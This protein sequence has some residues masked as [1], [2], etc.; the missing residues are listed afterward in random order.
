[1]SFPRLFWLWLNLGYLRLLLP[2]LVLASLILSVSAQSNPSPPSTST[3][4]ANV[5]VIEETSSFTT[6]SAARSGTQTLSLVAVLPTVVNVT[7]TIAPTPTSSINASAS[8]SSTSS[9]TILA[10]KIDPA[11]GVLGSVLILTGL[12]SAFLGHKNR[13]T[14]FFLIGFYTLSL[15]CFALIAN[16][17]ILRSVNPPS[18]T[19]RGMFVLS[20][21][22]AGAAGGGFAIFFW[23][24]TK[25][26][27][28]A[29]GGLAFGLWIQC[30]RDGGLIRP[31]GIRWLM[32]IFCSVIGFVLCTIPK[33]HYQILLIATAFVGASAVVLGAD[34]FSTA[35]LKEF[36]VWNIGFRKLFPK[37]I[38]HNIQFPV[39]QAMQIELGLIGAV[40]L[41]GIA[42]QL[43]ILHVLRRKLKEIAAEQKRRERQDNAE[44]AERFSKLELEKAEW[45]KEHPGLDK[46]DRRYSEFSGTT[47]LRGGDKPDDS[48][49]G[50]RPRRS[51]GLSEF[52]AAGTPE[53]ELKRAAMK[54]PQGAG[55]LPVLDLGSDI[56]DDVPRAFV[57]GDI[58]TSDFSGA[59]VVDLKA[60]ESLL[61]EI[62]T[63]RRSIEVLKAETPQ[64]SSGSSSRQPSVATSGH[65]SSVSRART[66]SYD[67]NGTTLVPSYQRPPR[68]P[69]PRAR[70]QSMD[71][72]TFDAH[73]GHS[74]GRPTSAP[75]RSDDW[76]S[77]LRDRKLLQPPS[78]VSAPIATTPVPAVVSTPR[79][80][81]PAAVQ[82]A[83]LRRQMRENL[84]E[85]DAAEGDKL[86]RPV[87]T[88]NHGSASAPQKVQH[89]RVASSPLSGSY[90]PPTIL[91]PRK[92]TPPPAQQPR[93]VAYEELTERHREKL[94]E[95]QAPL[96]NAEKEQAELDVAKARWERSKAAERQA[97]TKRQAERAAAQA[98]E[99]R[100]RHSE[101]TTQEK[102][103]PNRQPSTPRGPP[104]T[105]HS[106]SKS[107]D[108]L[109]VIS[110]STGRPSPARL[111]MLKVEDWQQYQAEQGHLSVTPI[112]RDSGVP[113]PDSKGQE[114]RSNRR[115]AGHPREPPN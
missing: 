85:A 14:S 41:M 33:I 39:S 65:P 101:D 109:G 115:T 37:Y 25:Y 8:A 73:I 19:L 45:E 6:T 74:I 55:V 69:D 20:S 53:E 108:K 26:F 100:R 87:S 5:T 30:F 103:K 72:P 61:Q 44:A 50:T 36:Y 11:F 59:K 92:V 66:L 49:L 94:R 113:F 77:Y 28:G 63:I 82:D 114:H 40:A 52:L 76:D 43:R 79:P 17:G 3:I 84:L 13:W 32:F 78:G 95:L 97:V 96:T 90:M 46:Y 68:Q 110:N 88:T 47:L 81:V 106:R 21:F 18:T 23:K 31:I 48:N 64:P 16:F 71:I 58:G 86:N 67:L 22:V 80:P 7:L 54:N 57:S 24:T 93:T 62:Q 75:L 107:A 1:M 35:G 89:R 98:T 105:R 91:P 2:L 99:A 60:R 38:E 83:L 27:I 51:S 112:R 34:C 29:W 4:L 70:N 9:P 56:K 102:D 111:S 10:T 12:P 15:I 42:V 104:P